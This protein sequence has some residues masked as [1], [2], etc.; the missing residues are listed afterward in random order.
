MT[1]AKNVA[2]GGYTLVTGAS[3][4]I[5]NAFAGQFSTKRQVIGLVFFCDLTVLLLVQL[6]GRTPSIWVIG[7]NTVYFTTMAVTFFAR[8]RI[9]NL[10]LLAGLTAL[11]TVGFLIP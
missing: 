10:V 3:G 1:E 7:L 8:G 5:G 9:T 2:G 11:M 4:R 6:M